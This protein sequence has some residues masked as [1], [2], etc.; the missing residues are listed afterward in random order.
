MNQ[1]QTGEGPTPSYSERL[2]RQL[3]KMG[4]RYDLD[5]PE[6][7]ALM[8][9]ASTVTESHSRN[10]SLGHKTLTDGL[11]GLGWIMNEEELSDSIVTVMLQARRGVRYAAVVRRPGQPGKV[12]AYTAR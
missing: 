8:R 7:E 12:I 4:Q 9:L 3:Q 11:R 1:L 10:F 2:S 5:I 6:M